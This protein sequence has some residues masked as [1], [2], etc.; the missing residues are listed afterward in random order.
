MAAA[1]NVGGRH[2]NERFQAKYPNGEVV[3][4]PRTGGQAHTF[5]ELSVGLAAGVMPD[6]SRWAG[7]W[8][9]YTCGVVIPLNSYFATWGMEPDFLPST[10]DTVRVKGQLQGMPMMAANRS[11]WI[12]D[13]HMAE[14]GLTAP[15]AW[16]MDDQADFATSLTKWKI[17]GKEVERYGFSPAN[18]GRDPKSRV[19]RHRRIPWC[20][21]G[22]QR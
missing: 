7:H 16:T 3:F 15:T 6:S 22:H 12:R 13:D 17:L 4:T 8:P 10:L 20:A 1:G 5:V 2:T 18:L 9:L 21:M 14:A 11:Y 19:K